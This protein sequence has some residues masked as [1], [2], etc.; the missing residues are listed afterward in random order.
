MLFV[1]EQL[2]TRQAMYV[3]SNIE[4]RFCNHCCSVKSV[5]V[6]F[7]ESVFVALNIQDAK[8]MRH[9]VVCGMSGC[10]ILIYIILEK[11]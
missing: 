8:P 1:R 5:R 2:Q 6:A 3:Q 9:F 11:A 4:V 7:C 10:T